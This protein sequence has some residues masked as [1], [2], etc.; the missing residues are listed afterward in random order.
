[1]PGLPLRIKT[2]TTLVPK[3]RKHIIF[4]DSGPRF[5]IKISSNRYRKSH[6]GDKTVVRS[7]YLH[8]GI[9]YT[10]KMTSLYWIRAL[11]EKTP[12]FHLNRWCGAMRSVGYN[13]VQSNM[14]SS[15]WYHIW[16]DWCKIWSWSPVPCEKHGF[17]R[18]WGPRAMFFTWHGMKSYYSTLPDWF[19]SMFYSHKYEFW[20]F[21]VGNFGSLHGC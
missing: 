10:G 16:Y 2:H 13:V 21:K 5:N 15:T 19:F 4:A 8:N 1:M 12:L 3:L 20:C 9:S 6:F 18:Y 7:S 11:D 14:G 17:C